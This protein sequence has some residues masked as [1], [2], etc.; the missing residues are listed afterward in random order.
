MALSAVSLRSFVQQRESNDGFAVVGALL[1][2]APV[3]QVCFLPI[4]DFLSGF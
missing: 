3:F 4:F 2:F 1:D